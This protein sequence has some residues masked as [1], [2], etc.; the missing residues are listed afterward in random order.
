MNNLNIFVS[1]TCYDLSQLRA[2]LHDFIT[3]SG[4]NP[5]LSEYD[6][7]PISPELNSIENCIKNVKENADILVLIV[8]NR[9]GSIIENGKSIT[10]TEFLMAKQKGIP[11]FCFIDK[12]TLN[13]LNFWK[14]NKDADFSHIVDNK[15]IFEFITDIRENKKIWTF[16]F[17]QSQ[18]IILTLKIQLSHL[19]KSSLKVKNILDR[20]ISDFFK[21]NLSEKCLKILIEK[22]SFFELEFLYQTLI[23]EIEKKEFLKNDIEYSILIEPKHFIKDHFDLPAW[24]SSRTFSHSNTITNLIGLSD[25]LQKF[26]GEP[27]KPSDIKGLY[28]ASVKYSQIYEQLLNWIIDIKSTYIDPEF[29][30][31]KVCLSD[32]ARHTA[33]ELW[34][35]PFEIREKIIKSK[36]E[37]LSGN[38]NILDLNLTLTANDEAHKKLNLLIKKLETKF[39]S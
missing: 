19:F 25:M 36:N 3:K 13:A 6:N 29:E 2:N 32:I 33:E 5:V 34:N 23:D 28:Y 26:I 10:N 18:D 27:G 14:N 12:N 16:P 37:E 4:H 9:Y 21:L 15:E 22:N 39:S 17:E 30:D 38:S 11:I 8:G 35:Y 7:F 24:A 1:S 31:F 20:D